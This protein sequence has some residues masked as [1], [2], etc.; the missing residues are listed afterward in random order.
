M[1]LTRRQ[2][3][4]KPFM[5]GILIVGPIIGLNIGMPPVARGQDSMKDDHAPPM[6]GA[7][8]FAD[9]ERYSELGTHQTATE[10]DVATSRWIADELKKAGYETEL[11][12][13]T[14][15]QFMLSQSTLAVAGRSIECFPFWFPKPTG[16]G[17]LASPLTAPLAALPKPE[18]GG[19]L[20][21]RIAFA[22]GSF[23]TARHWSSGINGIVRHAADLGAVGLIM[24]VPNASGEISAINARDP[25]HQEPLPIPA[26]LVAEGSE[27]ELA[28]AAREGTTASLLIAGEDRKDADAY[29]IIGTLRRG[30]RW[31][32]VTTPSSGWFTCA[33]ERGAGVAYFLG[34]ARWAAASD[35]QFSYMFIAN[36]GHELDNIGAHHS[37]DHRAPP[38]DEVQ[39]WIH[40]GASIATRD[41]KVTDHGPEPLPLV[42]TVGN[43]VGTP[44]LLPVL[45]KAFE[46]VEGYQPRSGEP[47]RGELRHFVN[48]GYT[49]F[50]F[51]GGHFYFHTPV[52]TPATTSPELL[53]PVGAALVRT[54]GLLE[55]ARF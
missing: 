36:S 46:G 53:A 20:D 2:T 54:M 55:K 13:W 22:D 25:N 40:L 39:C 52:D 6:S 31:I 32:V 5:L 33:G 37:L 44:N 38:V 49:T 8:L 45:S 34:L 15:R 1:S 30:E 42:N 28:K 47:I 9:V 35:S 23:M 24:V 27:A 3:V 18:E 11:Q 29:N 21:G 51:F 26:V 17:T 10:G 14:L 4:L 48:S 7:A 43:L 41:W 19:T 50:G 12:A 16:T